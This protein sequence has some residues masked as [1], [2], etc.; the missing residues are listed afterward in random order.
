M[1]T[2]TGDGI[3]TFWVCNCADGRELGGGAET[4][5]VKNSRRREDVG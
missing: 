2:L 1:R 4:I 5:R 3:F